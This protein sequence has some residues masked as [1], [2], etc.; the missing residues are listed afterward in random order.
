MQV[1][2][3]EC[4]FTLH[5]A[6]FL[7]LTWFF[8]FEFVAEKSSVRCECKFI[9]LHCARFFVSDLGFGSSFRWN[10]NSSLWVQVHFALGRILIADLA[11][12]FQLRGWNIN[13]D[14]W[15]QVHFA[16]F[17]VQQILTRSSPHLFLKFLQDWVSAS[18]SPC[19][20]LDF[21]VSDLGFISS[22]GWNINST[23]WVQVHFALAYISSLTCPFSHLALC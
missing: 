19:T 18:S 9:T 1:Q 14:R 4:K 12:C 15:V 2:V 3:H 16:L 10:I 11:F 5:C 6:C 17:I 20:A 21:F 8:F 13:R 22:F 7:L 23:M